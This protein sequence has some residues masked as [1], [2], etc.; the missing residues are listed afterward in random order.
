MYVTYFLIVERILKDF[1]QK[2][3][4]SCILPIGNK[5]LQT[6]TCSSLNHLEE[7]RGK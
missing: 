6:N 1:G 7:M 3:I 5:V 4:I 2:R